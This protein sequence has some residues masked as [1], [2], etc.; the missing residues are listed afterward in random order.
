M[1]KKINFKKIVL[2]YILI[3]FI[4]LPFARFILSKA[5]TL[6][7]CIIPVISIIIV[8]YGAYRIYKMVSKN[9]T[10]KDSGTFGKARFSQA[11]EVIKT[12]LQGNGIAVSY[13]H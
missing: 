7:D 12:E 13:T 6:K 10:S 8:I 2:V 5:R 1:S 9:L 4:I 11:Y 3:S